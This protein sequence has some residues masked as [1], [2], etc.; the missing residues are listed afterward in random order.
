VSAAQPQ[1]SPR[2]KAGRASA[3]KRKG[4]TEFRLVV[5]AQEMLV[6]YEPNWTGG[7]FPYGHFEFRSPFEP[8]RRIPVSETGYRSH[9][10]PMAAIEAYE[11]AEEFARAFV[12]AIL[13]HSGRKGSQGATTDQLSLF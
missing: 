3:S 12:M 4:K 8:P 2:R 13:D 11:S 1:S 7:E 10:A 5:Q 9:F 6:S